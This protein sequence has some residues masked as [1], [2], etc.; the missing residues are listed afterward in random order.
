MDGGAGVGDRGLD[1]AAGA[2][3]VIRLRP[4]DLAA[5]ALPRGD[6]GQ[7]AGRVAGPIPE[8]M[9]TVPVRGLGCGRCRRG[10]ASWARAGSV[11][12]DE[13]GVPVPTISANLSLRLIQLHLVVIYAMAAM[14]KLQGPSWWDGTATWKTMTAGEFVVGDFTPMANWPLVINL[15][16]HATLALELLYPILI[17]IAIAR[18]MVLAYAVAMHAGIAL[19]SPGL[20]EFTL[21]MLT[22]NLAFVSGSWLRRLATGSDRPALRVLF[23]GA[24]PRCRASIALVTAADPGD[25]VEPIDL[26]AVDVRSIHPELTTE[27]LHAVDARRLGLRPGHGRVRCC[28]VDLWMPATVLAVRCVRSPS[29]DR[30]DRPERIQLHCGHSTA[31]CP[32]H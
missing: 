16:T 23:D 2:D 14:G 3:R 13:P 29:G 11:T 26:T 15:L 30:I 22:A 12:P 18:P 5:D 9:A 4:G 19:M 7:R 21:A 8:A 25:V 24:C 10:R 20:T 1:R 28:A 31:R 27:A 32:L 6:G 17:W